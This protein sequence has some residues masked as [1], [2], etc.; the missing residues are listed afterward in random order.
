MTDSLK[1]LSEHH[2]FGGVQSFH[3]HA[4]HEIGLPMRWSTCRRRLRRSACR[5]FFTLRG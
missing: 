1:T 2:A 3:E 4:S 5:P